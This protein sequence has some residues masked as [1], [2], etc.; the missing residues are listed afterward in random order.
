MISYNMTKVKKE[1]D[2]NNNNSILQKGID[3]WKEHFGYTL[4][5]K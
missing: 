1:E 3:L 5:G 2:N 4:R